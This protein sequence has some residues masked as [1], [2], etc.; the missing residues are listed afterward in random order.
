M[1]RDRG[2]I[3]V[4]IATFQVATRAYPGTSSSALYFWHARTP[5]NEQELLEWSLPSALCMYH[6]DLGCDHKFTPLHKRM[7]QNYMQSRVNRM[8]QN[9]TQG[10]SMLSTANVVLTHVLNVA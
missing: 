1:L 6:Y 2:Y 7:C 4:S 3:N 8:S 9:T 5:H 10:T